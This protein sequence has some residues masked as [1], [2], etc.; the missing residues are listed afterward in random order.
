MDQNIARVLH[1]TS[2]TNVGKKRSV[3]QD[4]LRTQPLDPNSPTQHGLFLVADGVGGNLPKGEIASRTA[5]DAMTDYYYSFSSNADMLERVEQAVQAAHTHV[6]EQAL[7]EGVTTIGTTLVGLALAPD[8]EAVAFNVGDSHIYLIRHGEI[9]LISEDQVSPMDDPLN[10]GRRSTKISTYVGQPNALVPNF[11]PIEARIGDMYVLCTDGV[12]SKIK[13]EE[14]RDTLL[15]QSTEQAAD[16]IVQMVLD[17]GAPDNLTLVIVQLGDPVIKRTRGLR[18]RFLAATLLILILLMIGFLLIQR[19]SLRLLSMPTQIVIV[20][21]RTAEA[22][23]ESEN[24]PEIQV[25][26][27]A[28]ITDEPT[29]TLTSTATLRPPTLTRTPTLSPTP[30][31]TRTPLPSATASPAP[32]ATRTATSTPT[33]TPTPTPTPTNAPP[34]STV[35]PTLVTFTP[36]PTVATFTPSPVPPSATPN[37]LQSIQTAVAQALGESSG[38]PMVIVNNPLGLSVREGPGLI[39]PRIGRGIAKGETASI[40]GYAEGI[41]G[42]KWYYVIPEVSRPGWIAD[43]VDG[44]EIRGDVSKVPPRTVPP[45]PTPTAAPAPT[46]TPTTETS[47]S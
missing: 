26:I 40:V 34:T 29:E 22:T 7:A 14:L 28:E 3:N 43:R 36:S 4:A 20:P 37:L 31:A 35:D 8:G 10:P 41:D 1:V 39:Y 15:S 47:N 23:V 38:E 24:T 9:R 21:T 33:L 5:V 46:E 16:T 13:D 18:N 19:E 32:S 25:P 2:R 17:R 42:R 11:F 12:W 45:T 6:R 30:S 27:A 44:V